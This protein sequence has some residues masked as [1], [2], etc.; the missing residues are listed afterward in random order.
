MKGKEEGE[1]KRRD[2][3]GKEGRGGIRKGEGW[4]EGRGE[5]SRVRS[6]WMEGVPDILQSYILAVPL[7]CSTNALA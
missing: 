1:G 5:V 3:K 7:F 2:E 4:K 6:E